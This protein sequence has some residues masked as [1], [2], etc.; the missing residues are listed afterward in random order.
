MQAEFAR[1][2]G[3]LEQQQIEAHKTALR[4]V[5]ELSAAQARVAEL[6]DQLQQASDEIRELAADRDTQGGV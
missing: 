5:G 1:L 6:H 3:A 2:A 4:L